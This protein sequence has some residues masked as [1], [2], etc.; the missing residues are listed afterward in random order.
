[1][2]ISDK[3]LNLIKEFEGYH[4]KLPNGNCT[5]YLC[6]SNIPTIGYGTTTYSN[7]IK[8]KLGDILTK[9]QAEQELLHHVKKYS[10]YVNKVVK[11][12]LNQ[13]QFNALVSLTY[14]IGIG[15]FG[16]STL[17]KKLNSGDYEGAAKEIL[18]W[19]K[20]NGGVVLPGLVRRRKAEFT[21][22]NS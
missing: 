11:V 19:N 15:A 9:Q 20:D 12:S 13:N 21:L 3:G 14:N 10:D 17:L 1:M 5:A 7:G 16:E 2:K 4:Q 8:V 6:P 18:R 22:F